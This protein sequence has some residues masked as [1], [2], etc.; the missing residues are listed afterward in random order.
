MVI[1]YI[2]QLIAPRQARATKESFDTLRKNE[3]GVYSD[4]QMAILSAWPSL[5]SGLAFIANKYSPPH[6]DSQGNWHDFD[7]LVSAG[8]HERSR[9]VLH[10]I[11]LT[12]SYA[13]GTVVAVCGRVLQHSC[14]Y[15]HKGERL[16]FV[17]FTRDNVIERYSDSPRTWSSIS[18]FCLV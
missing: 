15:W 3:K 9:L 14:Q 10:D 13:P 8:T 7:L 2:I 18:D 12:F 1:N 16:C 4:E 5:F 6:R 17:H 11:G